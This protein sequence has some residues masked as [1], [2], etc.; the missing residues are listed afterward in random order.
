MP[1]H[2]PGPGTRGDVVVAIRGRR[3]IS[4]P[5]SPGPSMPLDG[6]SAAREADP[7]SG[8]AQTM[9]AFF[10]ARGLTLTE[11]RTG[12]I[13]AI[14]LDAVQLM[15]DGALAQSRMSGEEHGMLR[16]MLEGMRDAPLLL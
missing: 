1:D 12:E 3:T 15:L 11:E 5:P 13:Y 10:L 2:A 6:G 8:L 9:E 14:A 7:L 16:G 4:Q